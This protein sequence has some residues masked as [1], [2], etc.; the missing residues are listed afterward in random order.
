MNKSFYKKRLS[1]LYFL[2]TQ[3]N[4]CLVK[5]LTLP[6]PMKP[7]IVPNKRYERKI[8]IMTIM[9]FIAWRQE[10]KNGKDSRK[11]SLKW[12][13]YVTNGSILKSPF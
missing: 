6:S 3:K 7:K 11:T 4:V 1:V 12:F 13:R 2:F 10:N 5:N 8:I 9:I